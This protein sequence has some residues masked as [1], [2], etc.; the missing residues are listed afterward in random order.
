MKT[1]P[2]IKKI[3]LV[4]IAVVGLTATVAGGAIAATCSTPTPECPKVNC[5]K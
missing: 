2:S 1:L 3:A 5:D 4:S